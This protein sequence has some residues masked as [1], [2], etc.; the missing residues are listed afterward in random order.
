M[1][2]MIR[3]SALVI[4]L[5]ALIQPL[6]ASAQARLS[7]I[8]DGF[9]TARRGR[10]VASPYGRWRV[11]YGRGA[12]WAGITAFTDVAGYW[13]AQIIP[14]I[15][16]IVS[17]FVS[18]QPSAPGEGGAGTRGAPQDPLLDALANQAEQNQRVGD[19]N[20][21]LKESQGLVIRLGG[22]PRTNLV[23]PAPGTG[24]EDD[25]PFDVSRTTRPGTEPAAK[26]NR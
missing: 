1:R 19:L 4:G 3:A 6:P 20:K 10:I 5:L 15:P 9:W 2:R 21:L 8:P 16:S 24:E 25:E 11:R 23:E 26:P 12:D 14:Y 13:G 17:P 7:D 18:P 22:T